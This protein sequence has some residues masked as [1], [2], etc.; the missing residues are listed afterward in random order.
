MECLNGGQ[1]GDFVKKRKVVK[2]RKVHQKKNYALGGGKKLIYG[3]EQ[4]FILI[5]GGGFLV[6]VLGMM[7][8]SL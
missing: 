7:I 1:G 5:V 3:L 8:L 4:D 6:V 2:H